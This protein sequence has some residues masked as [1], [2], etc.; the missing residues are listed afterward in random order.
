MFENCISISIENTAKELLSDIS[1]QK[2]Q[3]DAFKKVIR[4]LSAK[5]K[6]ASEK[7]AKISLQFLNEEILKI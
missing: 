7:A 4:L 5:E 3:K 6:K 2:N 1:M